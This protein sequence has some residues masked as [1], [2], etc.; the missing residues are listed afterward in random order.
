MVNIEDALK[1]ILRP[2]DEFVSA[3]AKLDGDI[4]L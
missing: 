2:S 3:V 4:L 1:E